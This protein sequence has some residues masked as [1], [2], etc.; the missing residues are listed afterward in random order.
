MILMQLKIKERLANYRR[1]LA[2]S[3]KPSMDEFTQTLKVA[4]IGIALIGAVGF[5]FFALSI[6]FIP[7]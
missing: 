1:V 6:L 7:S 4:L 3:R 5:V 2:I